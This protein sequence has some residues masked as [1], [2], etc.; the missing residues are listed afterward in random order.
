MSIILESQFH[1]DFYGSPYYFVGMRKEC[2]I[3]N[4]GRVNQQVVTHIT[5]ARWGNAFLISE[6]QQGRELGKIIDG[7][8]FIEIGE[9]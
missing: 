8:F 9:R 1:W 6:F 3:S 7:S 2:I 5:I 4:K